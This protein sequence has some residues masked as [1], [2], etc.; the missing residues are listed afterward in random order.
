MDDKNVELA[1]WDTAGQ[2]DYDR[3]RP[4][5]YVNIDVVL[6]CFSIDNPESL[7]NAHTKWYPEMTQ[8][9]PGVPIV[10]CGT[11]KDLRENPD[12]IAM[13]AKIRQAPVSVEQG[14]D[15][16]FKIGA[17]AYM[18]CSAKTNEGV[19]D[20]FETATRAVLY[21]SKKGQGCPCVVL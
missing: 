14:R 7:D 12:V 2:E 4:I 18:E 11:K 1:L 6:M 20:I 3:L 15:L 17:H 16:A 13:L 9:C 5:S 21:G 8:F 10:L 19:Q